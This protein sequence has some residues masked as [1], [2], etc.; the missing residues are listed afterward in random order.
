[1]FVLLEK[2]IRRGYRVTKV[3]GAF[4]DGLRWLDGH[5]GRGVGR[6]YPHRSIPQVLSGPDL[7]S[8]MAPAETTLPAICLI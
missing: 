6:V 2:I 4:P 3:T 7:V 5:F 8:E 1:M